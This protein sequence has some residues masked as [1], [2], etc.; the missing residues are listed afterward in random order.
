MNIVF[1][2]GG[3]KMRFAEVKGN[4]ISEPV[5]V[6]TPDS[7]I[8]AMAEISEIIFKISKGQ[9]V[10]CLAGGIA[11]V[12]SKDGKKLLLAPNLK[13]WIN[14]PLL[15]DL[16]RLS[17]AK[18]F[19]KNDTDMVALGEAV[20]GAGKNHRIVAYLT[21]ST[22]IGGSLI[23]DKNLMSYNFGTE[24]GFQI[25]D[26]QDERSLHSVAGTELKK[27]YG[28]L[29]KDITD[30]DV[31]K[32]VMKDV[33]AGIHNTIMFWSPDIVVLGGGMTESFVLD[34][35]KNDLLKFKLRFPEL[36]EIEFSKLEDFG[37]LYGSAEFINKYYL[38]K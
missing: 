4:E 14:R 11:G 13:D 5:V 18:V 34:D 17:G 29:F 32:K 23:I 7:Y 30:L 12:L 37:G 9:K 6:K 2:I 21:F 15:E 31:R 25:I 27:D 1:D 28:L 16:S 8:D 20:K 3:T 22:G 38:A 33:V 19:I 35:I 24:P 36:P 26:S 10:D